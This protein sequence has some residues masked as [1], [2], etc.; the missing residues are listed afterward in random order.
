MKWLWRGLGLVAV[1]LI[2]V[3]SAGWFWL[4]TSL[5]ETRG[6]LAVNGPTAPVEIIRDKDGVPHIFAETETDAFFALGF[7][8]AQDRLWQMEMNR[9]VPQGRVAEVIG[10]R[11]LGIDRFMRTLGVGRLAE[12]SLAGLSAEA[13]RA[14][15]AYAAGVNSWI[16][17]HR[18]SLP[19]EFLLLQHDPEPWRPV[20]SIVWGGL[21]SLQLSGNWRRELLRAQ[22][23]RKI[24]A[25]ALSVLYPGYPAQAPITLQRQAGL[26][27]RLPLDQLRA[28]LP[29]ETRH[30]SA[31]NQWV[32]DGR[33]SETGKPI[34]AN[35]PHLGFSAPGLWYLVRI[36]TPELAVTGGTV[37]G[38]PFV[39]LGHNRRIAWGFTTTNGDQQ[40]LFIEKLDPADPSRYLTPDGP[41]PFVTRTEVIRVRGDADVAMTVRETRHGPVLND[42]IGDAPA[43]AGE[44]HV[45]VLAAAFLNGENHTA[46][47]GYRLNHA[48]NWSEFKAALSHWQ[49]PQQN[50]VYA[51][52][53]GNIGFY[54]PARIPIRGKGDGFM[55]VPGWTGEHDWMGFIPFDRLPQAYNPA[56]G[57]LVNANNRITA[58]DYPYLISREWEAPYRA[59]RIEQLLAERPKFSLGGT[60][61]LQSD[62]LS[63]AAR[64][65]LPRMLRAE[66]SDPKGRAAHDLL[67]AWD[68]RMDRTRP[69]PLL[70]TAWLRELSRL[71]YAPLLGEHLKDYM[72]LRPQVLGGMLAEGGRWCADPAAGD[73]SDGCDRRI[74]QALADALAKLSARYGDDITAWRW[75]DAHRAVFRHRV[76]ELV[77]VV[78]RHATFGAAT[79]GGDYTVNRGTTAFADDDDPFRHVHGAGLRAVYDLSDLS[80]SLFMQA[81]GQS[82]NPLSSHYGDLNRRWADSEYLVLGHGRETLLAKGGRRL[83]LTPMEAEERK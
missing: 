27:R 81:A 44:G 47:A 52:V 13:R 1:L 83:V 21:M 11:G 74:V 38:V 2:L 68:G 45:L 25:E 53:D 78:G 60:A 49:A 48:G 63:L 7:V 23:A 14:L 35:D 66:P 50:M 76:L 61:A 62:A 34:L 46:E 41:Q 18:G 51:D 64:E 37:P 56:D 12:A 9:R 73:A 3:G 58:P 82:G 33:R 43:V 19:P 17:R 77:P 5:P 29:S 80:R 26:Y 70:F 42:V 31:S 67:A 59:R 72:R 16:A 20:D 39:I 69:E 65:L 71:L 75:G 15:D 10:E 6:I 36:E 28:A 30:V 32:V 22:L 4:R 79:H 8:H 57:V 54:A 55:P 40:D 24:D